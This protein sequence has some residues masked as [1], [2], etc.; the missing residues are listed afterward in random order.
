M[1]W[2]QRIRAHFNQQKLSADLDEEL[3]FHIGMREQLNLENGMSGSEARRQARRDLGNPTRLK[4][5]MR[6]IDLYTFPQTVWQ[7][8]RF[9]VRM[10]MKNPGFTST[11]ILAL[12]LGIG[13]NTAVF[14]IYRAFLL[15]PLDATHARQ[16]VNISR[17]D[18]QGKY[19]PS[20]SY[21]DFEVYRDR[22][23]VFSGM[24]AATSDEVAL[25]GVGDAAGAGHE[26][27]GALANAA[28]FR[29]PSVMTGGAEYV[30][31][32]V[33]SD[34]Y[35]SVLGVNPIRGR[36]FDSSNAR[37]NSIPSVMVSENYWRIKFGGDPALIGKSIKLNGVAFAVVG[38]T[39][40]DFMGTNL[41]V[42]NFWIPLRQQD[43]LHPGTDVVHDRENACCRLY[44]R[45]K[46]G[47]QPSEAQAEMNLLAEQLRSL[48]APHSD[49]SKPS[50]VQVY[51]GSPFGRDIDINLKFAIA[52]IMCAVGMVLLIACANLASLQLARSA[53]RQ[54][55]IG[56]RLSLGASRGRLIR[57]LLTESA[58]L[59]LLAGVVSLF[60]TWW[61]LRLLIVEISATLPAD[62]G[63]FALHVTPDMQIFGYVF[64]ISILAGVLFGLMPALESSKPNLTSAL[65]DEGRH[66]AFLSGKGRLRDGLIVIQVAVCLV[67][68]IS[69]GLLIRSSFRALQMKTGYETRHV[70]S[71]DLYFPDGF[72]YTSAK[73]TSEIL[74]LQTSVRSLPGVENVSIGRP[75]AGGGMR[76]A[77][78]ALGGG[79]AAAENSQRTLYYTYVQPNYFQ[80]LSIP[81]SMG[82]GF[83]VS[84]AG[85]RVVAIVSESAAKELWPGKNPIGQK[86]VLDGSHQ[87]HPKEELT[88]N[89]DSY[90]VIGVAADTRA[91]LI[92]G[93]DVRKVY[94]PLPPDRLDD[95]PLLIRTSGDPRL[96]QDAIGRVVRSQDSNMVVYSST[97][98]DMLTTSPQFVISRCSALFASIVGV[99]GLL[100]A[101]VGIYGTLSY[102]V[103]RR[104][105]EVGIRM[106]L[107]AT[108]RNVVNLILRESTH[109]VI[110]GL[111]IG[112]VGAIGAAHLM[113]AILFGVDTFDAVSFLGV[114][115]LF[116][117][118][119]MVA[120]YVPA[121][122]AARVDPIIA[123]RYE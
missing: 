14:T 19:D 41:S 24:I 55:E 64:G 60:L 122:R 86:F 74:E 92:D 37:D 43:L 25:S 90:Q 107:G 16:L 36:V 103:V 95:R 44:G 8:I 63:S 78:V 77:T 118:I 102:A 56:I 72:G 73:E 38:I 11:A 105:R 57:Q 71:L 97:L 52:L 68:M 22:N 108:K 9:A 104:T 49:F 15:R 34:N 81:L 23:H 54:S 112:L 20:F 109:P 110:L 62:W 1:G 32:S 53:A 17:T 2:R 6:E 87:F 21:A 117:L 119:A 91:A 113:R 39:P 69:G 66:F 5:Q 33:V 100:L 58:L 29:L 35:F 31:T 116:F 26:M 13:I 4:E 3:Q 48:H 59:G 18:Y 67:L 47:I 123:L 46:P 85:D 114:S 28:G 120:A 45:L 7:D 111:L 121:R 83:S 96:L 79:K 82:R 70:L 27:I 12:G 84:Q 51:P 50:T 65:K 30:T 42:P 76:D 99:L 61:I 88:P 94:L 98:E 75:P 101:S 80:T 93:T 89:G 115:A 106:A 10:L 40:H